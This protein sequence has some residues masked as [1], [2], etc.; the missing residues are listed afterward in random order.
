MFADLA[1]HVVGSRAWGVKREGMQRELATRSSHGSFRPTGDTSG[2]KYGA[3]I[4]LWENAWEEFIPFLAYT[5]A[6][7]GNL[8][9]KTAGHRY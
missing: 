2:T 4:R 7:S 6:G 5:L 3:I 9:M 8:L 1:L